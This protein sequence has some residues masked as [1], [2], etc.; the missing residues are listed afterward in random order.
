MIEDIFGYSEEKIKMNIEAV[1][2]RKFKSQEEI[3]EY[4][5]EMLSNGEIVDGFRF[6][7]QDDMCVFC[8]FDYSDKLFSLDALIYTSKNEA[9][10][11]IYEI[12]KGKENFAINKFEKT[13][14]RCINQYKNDYYIEVFKDDKNI[15]Q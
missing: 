11:R 14:E 2:T 12:K 1:T 15:I 4:M 8:M 3:H 5:M 9:I 7:G 10:V 13:K 6:T